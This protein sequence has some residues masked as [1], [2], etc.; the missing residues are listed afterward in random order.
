MIYAPHTTLPTLHPFVVGKFFGEDGLSHLTPA[1]VT[2]KNKDVLDC[3]Y[4]SQL[5]FITCLIQLS[6]RLTS[7]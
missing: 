2:A 5:K 6:V 4:N 7:P 1:Q 3:L